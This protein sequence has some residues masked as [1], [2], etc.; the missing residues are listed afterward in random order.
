MFIAALFAIDSKKL[1]T[2]QMSHDRKHGYINC[3]SFT[4]WNTTQLFRMKTF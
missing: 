4:Q 3:G 2:T 1:E